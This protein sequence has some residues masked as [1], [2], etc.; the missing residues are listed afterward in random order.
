MGYEYFSRRAEPAFS[1][2][3]FCYLKSSVSRSFFTRLED[4]GLQI[5]QNNWSRPIHRSMREENLSCPCLWDSSPK[6][7]WFYWCPAITVLVALSKTAAP[8]CDPLCS[9]I[10]YTSGTPCWSCSWET[11]GCSS[12]P[13]PSS[14]ASDAMRTAF[15]F[16]IF[17]EVQAG[18]DFKVYV[19]RRG[20]ELLRPPFHTAL[21]RHARIARR[22]APLCMVRRARHPP[23]HTSTTARA[24]AA[25]AVS[26]APN[27]Q[28]PH[29]LRR[30]LLRVCVALSLGARMPDGFRSSCCCALLRRDAR[31]HTHTRA[32]TDGAPVEQVAACR[33]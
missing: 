30:W 16:A 9:A 4:L 32:S 27:P 12:A 19:A 6:N 17:G 29:A 14:S 26:P 18:R 31:A 1:Y 33:L 7:P 15:L 21:L 22:V 20:V 2:Y 11:T 3:Y 23:R 28:A 24:S 10:R 5:L 25:P 13:N 8:S